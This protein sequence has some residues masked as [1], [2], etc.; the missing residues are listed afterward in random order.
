[1][2]EQQ[3]IR[4]GALKRPRSIKFSNKKQ[5]E[6]GIMSAILGVISLFSIVIALVL[7]YVRESATPRLGIVVMLCLLL[8][9]FASSFLFIFPFC[10]VSRILLFPGCCNWLLLYISKNL[11]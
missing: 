1:M 3:S 2:E 8:I 5:S 6:T 7:S 9:S 11:S 4:T 10:G